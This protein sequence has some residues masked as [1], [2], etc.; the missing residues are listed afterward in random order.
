MEEQSVDNEDGV[1]D[2]NLAF[3]QSVIMFELQFDGTSAHKYGHAQDSLCFRH[4]FKELG[5][6]SMP[7]EIQ[8]ASLVVFVSR[9]KIAFSCFIRPSWGS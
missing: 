9:R 7:G 3:V 5:S 1:I 2:H 4:G 8:W 6:Q